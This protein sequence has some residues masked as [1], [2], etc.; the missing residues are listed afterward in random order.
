M[1]LRLLV[2]EVASYIK[3]CPPTPGKHLWIS[4]HSA[5]PTD[6]HQL[7]MRGREWCW[8]TQRGK[9]QSQTV[10]VQNKR[11]EG[12]LEQKYPLAMSPLSETWP[13][14]A[15]STETLGFNC[16]IAEFS[17]HTLGKASLNSLVFPIHSQ[18]RYNCFSVAT[19]YE[20]DYQLGDLPSHLLNFGWIFATLHNDRNLKKSCQRMSKVNCG[21]KSTI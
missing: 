18:G 16:C 12:T 17:V 8:N 20:S 3:L 4:K 11:E 10:H 21:R 14:Y 9:V 6:L 2:G 7:A 13:S 5:G 1:Y 15:R 19:S